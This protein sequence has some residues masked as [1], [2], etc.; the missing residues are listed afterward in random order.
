M[1]SLRSEFIEIA[2]EIFRRQL[3]NSE[4]I[5]KRRFRG[6]FGISV[7]VCVQVWN[8]L[9]KRIPEASHPRHLLWALLFLKSY[10]NETVISAMTGSDEKTQR[11]WIWQFVRAIARLKLV[12]VIQFLFLNLTNRATDHME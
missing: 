5:V 12:S 6:L 3:G 10:A 4:V 8:L 7:D 11:L 2:A 9:G 1:A